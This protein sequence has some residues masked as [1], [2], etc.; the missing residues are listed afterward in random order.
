MGMTVLITNNTLASR[1]GS[2][3]YVRDLDFDLLGG[4]SVFVKRVGRRDG[5]RLPP[6]RG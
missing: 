2:E 5:N 3:L 1:S 4:V 6:R